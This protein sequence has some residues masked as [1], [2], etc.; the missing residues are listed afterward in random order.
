MEPPIL[1]R[2]GKP[3]YPTAFADAKELQRLLMQ[4]ARADGLKPLVRAGIARAYCELEEMKR[5]LRMKP[6]PKAID[7]TLTRKGNGKP[8]LSGISE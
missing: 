6:L 1:P 8:N 4:D 3:R 5:R 7:V 2:K